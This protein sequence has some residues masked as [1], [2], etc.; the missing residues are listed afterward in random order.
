MKDSYYDLRKHPKMVLNRNAFII[1]CYFSAFRAAPSYLNVNL[2]R[3][4]HTKG[5]IS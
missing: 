2:Y 5:E 3:K 1:R 4:Q